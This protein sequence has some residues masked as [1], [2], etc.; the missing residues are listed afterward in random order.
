MALPMFFNNMY[1]GITNDYKV[2]ADTINI[3]N[4][5]TNNAKYRAFPKMAFYAV[6]PQK[7]IMWR[8]LNWI[9][10]NPNDPNIAAFKA[11]DDWE[12]YDSLIKGMVDYY[13][14]KKMVYLNLNIIHAHNVSL[15]KNK[16]KQAQLEAS[17][18]ALFTYLGYD[19]GLEWFNNAN[20][21]WETIIGARVKNGNTTTYK[22]DNDG[23]VL[24]E[25]AAN[26]P[27]AT[28]ASVKIF[29]NENSTVDINKGSSHMQVRND[30]GIREH[31]DKLFN[32]DY[33]KW[34]YV[35]KQ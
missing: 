33:E 34:F 35:A 14:A 27:G 19:Q 1:A 30:E 28:H 18:N 15:V 21:N 29:P 6:E 16:H 4:S 11:N 7:N 22:P 26:L 31:L 2:G 25:S 23:V 10:N 12:L 8:T 20:E 24:A 3:L 17:Y 32:G 9:V 5:D 13:Q